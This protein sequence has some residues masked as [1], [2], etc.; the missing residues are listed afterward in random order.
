VIIPIAIGG[1]TIY[2]AS[3][4]DDAGTDN[5]DATA[6]CRSDW[7]LILESLHIAFML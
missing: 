5:D 7:S 4:G 2:G 3:F 1:D 6:A